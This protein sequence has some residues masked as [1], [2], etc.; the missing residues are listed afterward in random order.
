MNSP[1]L[2]DS[3][4]VGTE[5]EAAAE[6]RRRQDREI[7]LLELEIEQV[8]A[9]L[10][11]SSN[12]PE[13]DG[14]DDH[15]LDQTAN[16][17]AL[18]PN[19]PIGSRRGLR[20]VKWLV[21]KLSY[22][23]VRFLT[24]QFN[25]F[26]GVL[27]RHLRSLEARLDRLEEAGDIS[28]DKS[29]LAGYGLIDEP[30]EPS[31]EVVAHVAGLAGT[32]PCLVLSAGQGAIV[33]AIG[34]RGIRA[35]GVEQN[36]E[37]VLAGLHRRIDIRS[38][39][40][41]AHLV[42]TENG[43]FGTIVLTGKLE[44]LPLKDLVGLVNQASVKVKKAGRIIVAVA[45]PATRS[46]VDSELG[47]G[48]GVSPI[49]WRHLLEQAGFEARLE[50]CSDSR[51][52]GDRRGSTL[53]HTERIMSPTVDLLIPQMAS[54]DATSN[55]TLL[56]QELLEEKGFKTRVVVERKKRT[57]SSAVLVEKWKGDARVSIL[58]HSI[59]SEVAQRVIRNKMQIVLNYHNITP[60]SYFQAWQP[61]LAKSVQR[62]RHQLT[63]LALLT[64]RGIADSEFNA[65]ELRDLGID[66]VVVSPVLWQLGSNVSQS[67]QGES[68]ISEDGGT[69]LFVGRLTPN[70]CQHDLIA[71]FAVLSRFRPQS[72]LVLVGEASP[73]QYQQSL[74]TLARRLDVQDRV[75]FAGKVSNKSLLQWYQLSDVLA[76][77]SEHE[78]FGVPLVEAMANGLPVVAYDAAAVAET[79]QGAGIVLSDK[80]PV[81]MAMAL[82]RVLS[83]RPLK[84]LL[85]DRGID[86]AQRF[87]I[88]VTREKMWDALKDLLE[89]GP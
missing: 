33:E 16:L 37:R 9:D 65:R 30:P 55:H 15:L 85:R 17:A 45:D 52:A 51:I 46:K 74:K 4:R 64:R 35:Y 78:G 49:T 21:R 32:G 68:E 39:G 11:P 24:D 44:T 48:L 29:V 1:D 14:E 13:S 72:R 42:G 54:G 77:A 27:V 7:A 50:P 76:S 12:R 60:A 18:D 2:V 38:G 63:Q 87:D 36:P 66:D 6:K 31:A 59:G 84:Q 61:E 34:E 20:G 53:L 25:V 62:G 41:L 43:E 28:V 75:V 26:A 19:V 86:S 58:Q 47:T 82:D 88:S 56:I 3:N 81:T 57:D 70:K 79:V 5:I 80:R 73:P 8:W 71:A 83:D 89:A 40:A 23:Y 22:W 10:A 67:V 69:V